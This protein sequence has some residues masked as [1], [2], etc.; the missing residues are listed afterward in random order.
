MDSALESKNIAIPR[1]EMKRRVDPS[2]G[3]GQCVPAGPRQ[4]DERS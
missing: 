4:N 3:G 2:V 1:R